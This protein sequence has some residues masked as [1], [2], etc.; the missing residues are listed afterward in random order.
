PYLL[1]ERPHVEVM[2]SK[3]KNNDPASEEDIW[4]PIRPR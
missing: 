2:G 4:I 1:D 3:Y